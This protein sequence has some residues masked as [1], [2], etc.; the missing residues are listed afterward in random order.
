[1]SVRGSYQLYIKRG[2]WASLHILNLI[3]LCQ[4]IFVME[5]EKNLANCNE[6]VSLVGFAIL[7]IL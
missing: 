4:T 2:V 7:C 1:M 5:L 6:K 3:V